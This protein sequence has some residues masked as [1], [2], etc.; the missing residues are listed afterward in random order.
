MVSAAQ[1]P[2]SLWINAV[3]ASEKPDKGRSGPFRTCQGGTIPSA[4][5]GGTLPPSLDRTMNG[6]LIGT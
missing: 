5:Y 4:A 1:I 6:P 3:D 2:I